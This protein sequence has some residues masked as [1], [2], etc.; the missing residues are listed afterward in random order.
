MNIGMFPYLKPTA[1]REDVLEAITVLDTLKKR[2]IQVLGIKHP[3]TFN[4]QVAMH[5]ARQKLAAMEQRAKRDL[6]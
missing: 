6:G 5:Q 4:I 3:K 1:S 2:L